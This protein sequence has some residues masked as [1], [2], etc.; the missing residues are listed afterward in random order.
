M[1]ARPDPDLVNEVAVELG[2][3]PSFVEK[4]WYAV[5]ILTLL[6]GADFGEISP[7]FSGGTSLSKGYGL[8]QRFSEDLDF[9]I[10]VEDTT[11][12]GQRRDFRRNVFDLI[13]AH[14][15]LDIVEDS[16]VRA[17]RNQ[18]FSCN[19]IYPQNHSLDGSLREHLKLEMS[20]HQ[21]AIPPEMRDIQTFM[22][23]MA[24]T[25]YETSIHCVSPIETAADK[26]SALL[27]RIPA[28]DRST[29]L[30]SRGNDPTIIRH[31][32]DLSAL[33]DHVS[34]DAFNEIV[35][36]SF[37]MDRGRGGI[38]ECETVRS[39]SE[40]VVEILRTE[41]AEYKEE[42]TRF[43]EAMSYAAD[44]DNITFD[45]AFDSFKLIAKRIS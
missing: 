9:K 32:H 26:F 15:H 21:T 5:Q 12:Q 40:R 39:A 37:Q 4:D 34:N 28:R 27:W 17:N 45:R 10:T 22:N 35:Q 33:E 1:N 11:S 41:E 14:E 18:F 20:F 38:E 24:G 23:Q 16:I 29:E 6:S 42:Y 3:A 25:G 36:G 44:G 19:I 13:N 31:L 7:V 8:I 43:V 30:R 2:V